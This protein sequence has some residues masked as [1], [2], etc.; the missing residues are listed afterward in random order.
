MDNQL[1]ASALLIKRLQEKTDVPKRNIRQAPSIDWA[2]DNKIDNSISII[3]FDDVPDTSPRGSMGKGRG[4]LSKQYWMLLIAQRNVSD[5]TGS[6][7]RTEAGEVFSQ[8]LTFLQGWPPSKEHG[9]LHREK[10]PFRATDKD[11]Y[12]FIP[13]LFSTRITTTGAG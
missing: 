2:I 8:V 10:S 12:V 1:S 3:F 9:E 4:Q 11:G 6:A 13:L 5:A 7:A